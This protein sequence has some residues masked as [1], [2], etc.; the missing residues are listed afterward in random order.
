[1]EICYL[2]TLY[3]PSFYYVKYQEK[4]RLELIHDFNIL[5]F[6]FHKAPNSTRM[7]SFYSSSI[8][9]PIVLIWYTLNCLFL[10]KQ[11]WARFQRRIWPLSTHFMHLNHN[12]H[13][14]IQSGAV[15]T[16]FDT[17]YLDGV[18]WDSQTE[19]DSNDDAI[20][21]T[22]KNWLSS[23]DRSLTS[24]HSFGCALGMGTLRA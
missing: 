13:S 17:N 23:S 10:L 7:I 6:I 24:R 14:I 11:F 8:P 20:E 2:N 9:R 12:L 15:L 3:L 18:S 5:V 1:M 19:R 22:R 16:V 4:S 21:W